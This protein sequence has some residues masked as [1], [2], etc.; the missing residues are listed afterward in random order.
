MSEEERPRPLGELYG[1][2]GRM[3]LATQEF[4]S[5]AF[6]LIEEQRAEIERLSSKTP[7]K[8]DGARDS[9]IRMSHPC[10]KGGICE[11]PMCLDF[12]CRRPDVEKE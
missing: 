6:K 7:K 3:A 9:R 12:G 4:I 5:M 1:A 8:D 11:L 10:P 2:V